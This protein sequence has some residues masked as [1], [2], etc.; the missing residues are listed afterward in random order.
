MIPFL[1][2]ILRL[3]ITFMFPC[4]QPCFPFVQLSKFS[5]ASQEGVRIPACACEKVASDL[6][7]G[8]G[9]RRLLRVP[10]LLASGLAT[11]WHKCDEKRNSKKG[12]EIPRKKRRTFELQSNNRAP[13]PWGIREFL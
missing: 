3:Y 8:G 4:F 2:S 6:W 12:K 7:L 10:P 11:I 13:V 9:F 5:R 1:S